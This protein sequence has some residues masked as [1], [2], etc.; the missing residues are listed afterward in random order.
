MILITSLQCSW[1]VFA[2]A[3]HVFRKIVTLRPLHLQ[4]GL[5]DG[6]REAYHI[7]MNWRKLV[8][9]GIKQPGK[10]TVTPPWISRQDDQ[11]ASRDLNVKEIDDWVKSLYNSP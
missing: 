10:S 2:V 3:R 7:K 8:Q 11:S 9:Q 6:D 4:A 1:C 5:S